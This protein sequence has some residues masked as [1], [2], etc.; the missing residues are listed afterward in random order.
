[1]KRLICV[2]CL[3]VC[4]Y[5][6][7]QSSEAKDRTA[8]LDLIETQRQAW[9]NNDIETFMASY[10]KSDSLKFYGSNGVT[11]GWENTLARY[12]KSYP[13]KAH[14][15]HLD[16]KINAITKINDGAYCVMGEYHLTRDIGNANGIFMIILKKI[17]GAWK[18]I[19][20]TSC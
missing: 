13:T 16:F 12:K 19:A 18:I 14:K 3:I 10:W 5:S 8:I 6:Q 20:D 17:D 15:G 9:N 11:H 7:A 2:L 1:M 4:F